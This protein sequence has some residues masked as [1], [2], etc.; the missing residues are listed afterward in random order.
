M[1]GRRT[2][3]AWSPTAMA[4]PPGVLPACPPPVPTPS[5]SPVVLAQLPRQ[6]RPAENIEAGVVSPLPCLPCHS[7]VF[8]PARSDDLFTGTFSPR[9][10][11]SILSEHSAGQGSLKPSSDRHPLLLEDFPSLPTS[12]RTKSQLPRLLFSPSRAGYSLCFG[13]YL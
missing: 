3:C 4:E 2:T 12:Y 8:S 7:C 13:P 5:G 6:K 9:S 11:C 10:G 1:S